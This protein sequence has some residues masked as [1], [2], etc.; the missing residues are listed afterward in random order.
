MSSSEPVM[1]PPAEQPD[2]LPMTALGA[3]ADAPRR[4]SP[5]EARVAALAV[6]V[7][8]YVVAFGMVAGT[9][10]HFG[11]SQ[12]IGRLVPSRPL[13]ILGTGLLL[14]QCSLIAIW[15][16]R[17]NWLSHAKTLLAISGWFITWALLIALF[18]MTDAKSAASGGWAICLATQTT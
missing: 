4:W 11:R 13:L 2:L 15:W 17:S 16:A 12:W 10:L 1:T 3:A 7:A 5:I 8:I 9:V 18:P 6:T 14:A